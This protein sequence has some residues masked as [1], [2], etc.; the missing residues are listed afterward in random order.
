[1]FVRPDAAGSGLG[2]A[3]L[4]AAI[5]KARS[6]EG[7]QQLILTVLATNLRAQSLYGAA[8]FQQFACEREAVRIGDRFVDELQMALFLSR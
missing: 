4:A 3:L 1:M 2:R 8:G 7:L 6:A 5:D